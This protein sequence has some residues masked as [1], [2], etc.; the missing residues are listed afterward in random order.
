ML[1]TKFLLRSCNVM[2]LAVE[3]EVKQTT[4][5]SAMR[6]IFSFVLLLETFVMEAFCFSTE[7]WMLS[8]TLFRYFWKQAP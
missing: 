6:A 8:S 1:F 7:L 5:N 2:A 4:T 3:H